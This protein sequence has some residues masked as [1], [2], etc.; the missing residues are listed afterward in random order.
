MDR[1][2]LRTTLIRGC[3]L[4]EIKINS[5]Q[6]EQ[7]L[8]FADLIAETNQHMN[9]TRITSEAEFAVKHFVDCLALQKIGFDFKGSGID[10][11]TGAG[12]PGVVIASCLTSDPVVLLDSL[13]KRV[14][15]LQKVTAELKLEHVKCIHSRAE[16]AAREPQYRETFQWATARAVAPLPVLLEYCAPFIEVGGC[17]IAMKGSNIEAELEDAANAIKVLNLTVEDQYRFDLPF[18]MGARTIIKFRKESA[19]SE[20]YPRKAGIPTKKPL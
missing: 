13:E 17:F 6:V 11:G 14:K 4:L 12:F 5:H 3:A 15:F 20:Q 2:K 19:I 9:L 8:K 16:D 7:L 10:V 18:E 1:E